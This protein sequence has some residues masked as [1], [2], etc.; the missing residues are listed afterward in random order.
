M[1]RPPVTSRTTYQRYRKS[2]AGSAPSHGGAPE[3]AG[4]AASATLNYKINNAY[5]GAVTRERRTTITCLNKKLF[6]AAYARVRRATP[7]VGGGRAG[8]LRRLSRR[9]VISLGRRPLRG[10]GP[11]SAPGLSAYIRNQFAFAVPQF[12]EWQYKSSAKVR[13]LGVSA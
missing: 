9:G 10:L 4:P 13:P 6:I 5:T 11:R 12:I 2:R 7:G 3:D 8:R 1:I